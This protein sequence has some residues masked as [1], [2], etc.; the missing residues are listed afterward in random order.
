MNLTSTTPKKSLEH[1]HACDVEAL[2]EVYDKYSAALF[3]VIRGWVQQDPIAEQMLEETFRTF[4][5]EYNILTE[6]HERSFI[7]LIKIARKKCDP[8]I[9]TKSLFP[10]LQKNDR[11]TTAFRNEANVH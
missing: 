3:G 4:A 11:S 6:K 5:V 1:K 10:S 2:S 7:C 8:Y 9:S